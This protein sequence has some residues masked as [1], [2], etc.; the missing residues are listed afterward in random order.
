MLLGLIGA[1]RI[2]AYHAG[3]LMALDAVDDMLIYDPVPGRAAAVAE[4]LGATAADLGDLYERADA[5]VIASSTDTHAEMLERA[6]AAGKP[7][8]CEKPIDLDLAATRRAVLAVEEAGIQVQMGFQRRYDPAIRSIRDR[9][10]AGVL[11]HV[12][13]V[14]SQT[15]DPAPPPLDYIPRSGG[16]FRDC[17]IH[18]IDAVRYAT[19]QEVVRVAAAGSSLGHP[20]IAE[21]GDVGSAAATLHMSGGTI[22]QISGLRLDPVGYDV[23]LE[24]FAENDSIAAGW[25]ARTPISSVEPGVAPPVDPIT[26]FWDRFED[27][28]RAEMEGFVRM[29]RGEEAPASTPR[30]AYENLRVAA[31]CDVSLAEN[32]IVEL[33]EIE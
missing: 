14:R 27:A 22:A 9:V 1:G 15:H 8:F 33:E 21:L 10:V 17:L 24:V 18:D 23:R 25:S 26:T 5:V 20:D 29:V 28:Y 2:G 12:F 4:G 6:A 7:A 11:G 16:I 3:V 19:G 30:D 32:R 31:A 13:L